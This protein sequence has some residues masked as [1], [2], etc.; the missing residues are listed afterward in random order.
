MRH[1]RRLITVLTTLLL[2]SL[3]CVSGAGAQERNFSTG[4]MPPPRFADPERER[5]LA[6]AFPEIERQF[7]VWFERY[8]RPGAVLGIIID[9]ELVWV[10]TAGVQDTQTRAPVT[11]DSVFRIASMTKSFTAMAVLKLRDEG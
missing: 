9:G 1:A 7:A 6:A 8:R 2:V 3:V 11:P 4:A 10:K 5:K